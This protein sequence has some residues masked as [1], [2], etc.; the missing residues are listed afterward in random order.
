MHK[1]GMKVAH[2][3]SSKSLPLALDGETKYFHFGPCGCMSA[4]YLVIILFAALT[5]PQI[6]RVNF[7]AENQSMGK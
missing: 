2:K 1:Y 7:I 5:L 4:K 3:I 6:G